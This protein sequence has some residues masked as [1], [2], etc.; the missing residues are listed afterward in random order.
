MYHIL[1]FLGSPTASFE[2]EMRGSADAT[3]ERSIPSRGREKICG[4]LSLVEKWLNQPF[5]AQS[6]VC[7]DKDIGRY[8]LLSTG[9]TPYTWLTQEF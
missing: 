1:P 3:C 6:N 5:S 8:F 2:G 9:L 7:L 4:L